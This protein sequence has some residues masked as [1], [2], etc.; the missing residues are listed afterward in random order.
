MSVVESKDH[1]AN[2]HVTAEDL[3]HIEDIAMCRKDT[4]LTSVGNHTPTWATT[5]QPTTLQYDES[6]LV[7]YLENNKEDKGFNISSLIGVRKLSK[8]QREDLASKLTRAAQRPELNIDELFTRLTNLASQHDSDTDPKP[9]RLTPNSSPPQAVLPLEISSYHELIEDGGRPVCTI[10]EL[11]D[12]LREP[13]ARH[14]AIIS[15]LTDSPDSDDFLGEIQTV[16]STQTLRCDSE[17]G[18][19]RFLEA[20]KR[21][22]QRVEATAAF[23]SNS[24][25]EETFRR[26]WQGMAANSQLPDGQAF[27][28]YQDAVNLRLVPHCFAR[29]RQ[30]KPNPLQQDVWTDWLEYL[31]YEQMYLEMLTKKVQSLEQQYY[32]SWKKLLDVTERNKSAWSS[33]MATSSMPNRQRPSAK[34]GNIDEQLQVAQADRDASN[35]TIRDFV[36]E[37]RQ[38]TSAQK[39]AHYQRHRVE[40]V[41]KEARSMETQ[42]ERRKME[43]RD[44]E[45]DTKNTKKRRRCGDEAPSQSQ[46][47]RTKSEK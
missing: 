31:N 32:E 23:A 10:E 22:F 28:A 16:F 30:L 34:S 26:L 44:I 9:S 8:V 5:T 40:W 43:S 29:R 20:S 25:F 35:K 15:W 3:L 14:R 27:A 47:K 1:N 36:R 39:A 19:L 46:S 24:E 7:Q 12:I 11:S 33:S 45:I 18:F 4:S 37:T 42:I 41:I 38:Y 6:Q 13:M 21:K 17:E 2:V